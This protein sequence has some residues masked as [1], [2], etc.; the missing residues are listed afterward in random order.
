MAARID[1]FT[2]GLTASTGVRTVT[3]AGAG[4]VALVVQ[5]PCMAAAGRAGPGPIAA[6]AVVLV[7]VSA[8]I[9]YIMALITLVVL[10]MTSGCMRLLDVGAL[11]RILLTAWAGADNAGGR[12][13]GNLCRRFLDAA[14]GGGICVLIHTVKIVEISVA[15]I[16]CCPVIIVERHRRIRVS[17]GWS[18]G[19]EQQPCRA[20][21]QAVCN[22]QKELA[23]CQY[24]GRRTGQ[25]RDL[26]PD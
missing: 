9:F 24:A 22:G 19:A 8:K 11:Q 20:Q 18:T 13:G 21:H 7:N 23:V 15:S 26:Q 3:V 4:C 6:V 16:G 12:T 25:Q 14:C 1:G 5:H 10:L 17:G 2:F